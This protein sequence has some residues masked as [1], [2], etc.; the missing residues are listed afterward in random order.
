MLE[1]SIEFR[2][3]QESLRCPGTSHSDLPCS[4]RRSSFFVGSITWPASLLV[5][6]FTSQITKKVLTRAQQHFFRALSGLAELVFSFGQQTE[7]RKYVRR[8]DASNRTLVRRP[9]LATVREEIGSDVNLASF[10]VRDAA[11]VARFIALLNGDSAMEK[12]GDRQ[13]ALPVRYG[14]T[15]P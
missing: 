3:R 10:L 6:K 2:K 14:V 13:G 8:L 1:N 9:I 11:R 5:D 4:L 12:I 7:N 15:Q